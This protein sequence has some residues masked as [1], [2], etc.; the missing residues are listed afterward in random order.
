MPEHVLLICDEIPHDVVLLDLGPRPLEVIK[1]LRMI[2]DGGLWRA[3]QTVKQSP[4]VL[5]AE[6]IAPEAGRK[7]AEALRAAG[8]EIDVRAS[9]TGPTS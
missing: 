6:R 9:S 2:F 7:W 8:A 3:R 1:V 4:P 5:L